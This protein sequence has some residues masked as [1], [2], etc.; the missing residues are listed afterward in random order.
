MVGRPTLN[1]SSI[2][3][4]MV[5]DCIKGEKELR[6]NIH[7]SVVCPDCGCSRTGYFKLL[8]HLVYRV[9]NGYSH[10]S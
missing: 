7:L 9:Y 10:L 8:P 3:W 6:T 4:A 1:K 5:L 2:A